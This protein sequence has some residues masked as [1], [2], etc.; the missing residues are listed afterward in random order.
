MV[1][2]NDY[3]GF[4]DE[5]VAL[6]VTTAHEYMHTVQFG[7]QAVWMLGL[8]KLCY[9]GRRFVLQVMNDNFQYLS[10]IFST[11]DVA[12]DKETKNLVVLL[13]CTGMVLGFGFVLCRT[14]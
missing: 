14:H 2:R 8:W 5:D 13:I 3:Y 11:P 1:I 7:T 12:L 4:G 9:L 10:E 6:S